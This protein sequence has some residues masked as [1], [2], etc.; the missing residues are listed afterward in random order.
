MGCHQDSLRRYLKSFPTY[1]EYR[2]QVGKRMLP[3]LNR[4]LG[5]VALDLGAAAGAGLGAAA[6][7]Q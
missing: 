1:A 7:G 3:W 6:A 4:L 2:R 5:A